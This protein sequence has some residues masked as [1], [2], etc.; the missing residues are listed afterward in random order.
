MF[1]SVEIPCTLMLVFRKVHNAAPSASATSLAKRLWPGNFSQP[2]VILLT[3]KHQRA[4]S[5]IRF[6]D[7]GHG[8]PPAKKLVFRAGRWILPPRCPRRAQRPAIFPA[9]ERPLL[10]TTRRSTGDKRPERLPRREIP[11]AELSREKGRAA[12]FLRLRHTGPAFEQTHFRPRF[13]SR[14]GVDGG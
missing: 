1:R 7:D 12:E 2:W 14:G 10:S 13:H 5:R 8:L 11:A 9:A 6:D 4:A 3:D